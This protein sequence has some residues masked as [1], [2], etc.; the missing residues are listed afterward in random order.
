M[1]YIYT[2]EDLEDSG[3]HHAE[4]DLEWRWDDTTPN[5]YVA[6]LRLEEGDTGPL[7]VEGPCFAVYRQFRRQGSRKALT[8]TGDLTVT[9]HEVL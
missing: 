7:D 8:V 3:T 9:I 2:E 6:H 5:T 1:D 4:H